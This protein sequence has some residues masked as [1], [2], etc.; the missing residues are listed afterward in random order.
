MLSLSQSEAAARSSSPH[1]VR[2]HYID[3]VACALR[4]LPTDLTA[5]E[6]RSLREVVPAA[7]RTDESADARMRPGAG[8]RTRSTLHRWVAAATLSVVLLA[9]LL[10]PYLRLLAREAYAFDRRH[11]VS[12]R[13]MARAVL[14][15]DRVGKRTVTL[16]ARLYAVR[17]G[18][19]AESM[20]DVGGYVVQGVG[21]GV[22]EG[23]GEGVQVLGLRGVD[24]KGMWV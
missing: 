14:A 5:E 3:G 8:V 11:R 10:L 16:A 17:D 12:D 13:V 18:Q 6:E 19:W 22:C 9:S 15:A 21:G 4:G 7:L 24:V 1:F 23:L 2:R 20:R